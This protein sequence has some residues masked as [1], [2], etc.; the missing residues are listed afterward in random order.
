MDRRFD[1]LITLVKTSPPFED[2]MEQAVLDAWKQGYAF[3]F[4]EYWAGVL[5]AV[6]DGAKLAIYP[7]DIPKWVEG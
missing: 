7:G 5:D 3:P 4:V 2:D 1:E 6:E